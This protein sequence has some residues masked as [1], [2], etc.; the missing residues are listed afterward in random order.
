MNTAKMTKPHPIPVLLLFAAATAVL[1]WL[2][3]SG[4]EDEP[5]RH[6]ARWAETISDLDACCRRK[7][8]KA[9]QYDHF[10]AIAEAERRDDAAR[11]FRAMALSAR[12]QESD[13][14]R[15]IVRLGGRYTPPVKVALFRGSTGE[16]L[17]RSIDYELRLTRACRGA[18]IDRALARGNRLAA[19][20]LIRAAASDI[21]HIVLMERFRDGASSGAYRLCPRCGN[22]YE[23]VHADPYCPICQT[24]GRNFID[25]E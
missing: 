19:R 14:A 6:V 16:N 12:L 10:A 8:V 15:V 22:L 18:G 9:E 13:C 24:A 23:T 1:V 11:L 25:M 20:A 21:R 17:A 2:L 5:P 4:V 3:L 7:H